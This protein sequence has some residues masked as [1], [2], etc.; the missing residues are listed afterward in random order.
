MF[1]LSKYMTA[2]ERIELFKADHPEMR[3]D[4][5]HGTYGDFIWVKAKVYRFFDDPLPC[6]TG[7]A[8]E[9]LKT[10]FAME[11]AETSAYARA[12]TNSGDVKYSTTKDGTKA[13]RANRAEMESVARTENDAVTVR[14]EA[15]LSNDWEGFLAG[16]P[17]VTTL[18]QGVELVQQSLAATVI[19]ECAHGQMMYK[20][21]TSAKGP[22]S[23]YVCTGKRGDQCPAKWNKK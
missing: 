17:K 3:Y 18:A 7:L 16:E 12:I 8:M 23:G 9:S 13:P 22:Y 10:Q 14:I 20:E 19:P 2:E 5:E 4:S 21:G 1:D 11:K 15:D 6:Y